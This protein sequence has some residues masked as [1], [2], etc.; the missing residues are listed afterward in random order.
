ME[1]RLQK[2][3]AAAGICSRR[4]AELYIKD[5][6]V[7]VDGIVVTQLGVKAD[8]ATQTIAFDNKP[9]PRP[10][11]VTFL[12]NKPKGYVTTMNDPQGR[13]V[14]AS[15][16]PE[17]QE[18]VFPV[19][20][21]DIDTEGAL[22]MTNDGDLAQRILHPSNEINRTYEALVA[23]R[24]TNR[25]ISQ[26]VKGIL[27]EGKMTWPA[28]I[29]MLNQLPR[30]TRFQVV[31]HEGRKRQVRKMFAAIGHPVIE[32]RRTAY[33]ELGLGG[34]RVGNY[35]KLAKKDLNKVFK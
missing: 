15:L 12:L 34:L 35:R 14:V 2:I 4:K 17:V 19:G 9:L 13:P 22:L 30:N 27:I 21:L 3:L 32:L 20:R 28:Q 10:Q 23:G 29:K 18:R 1:E 6:R 31:I 24:P 25:K 33:G 7:K 26:L 5:G 8:L 11:L 16:M